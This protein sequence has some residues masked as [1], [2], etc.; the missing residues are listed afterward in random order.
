MPNSIYTPKYY[1]YV[2]IDPRTWLPFLYGKGC[3][4]RLY[5]HLTETL[6]NTINK[7]KFY[8][9]RKLKRLGLEPIIFKHK[10]KMTED[11]AYAFEDLMI[12]T[13]GG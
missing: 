12:M 11:D 13:W 8:R 10:E 1:V 6:E 3:D 9:I 2:Y 4:D 7:R 5:T